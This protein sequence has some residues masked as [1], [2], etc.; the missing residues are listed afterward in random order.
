MRLGAAWLLLVAA[1]HAGP[2]EVG[3]KIRQDTEWSGEVRLMEDVV[4]ARGVTLTIQPGTRIV[5]RE[6]VHGTGPG[7]ND[8]RLELHVA[9]RILA[10]GRRAQPIRF[11][12]AQDEEADLDSPV[13]LG[14]VMLHRRRERSEF[15]WCVFERADTGI[16]VA[17]ARVRMRNCVFLR[18]GAGVG[19]SLWA[20]PESVAYQARE[21][22]PRLERCRFAH[23]EVG[24]SI[25]I[26]ARPELKRCIFVQCDSG[27]ANRR[28]GATY[29]HSGVGPL[30]ERCEFLECREAIE[31]GSRVTNSIFTANGLVFSSSRGHRIYVTEIDR[32]LRSHNL[33]WDNTRLANDDIPLGAGSRVDDPRR[34]GELPDEIELEFLLNDPGQ[35]LALKEG[36]PGRGAA[37]DQ[38]DL[39]AFGRAGANP[40]W[41]VR[42]DATGG[43]ALSHWLVAWSLVGSGKTFVIPKSKPPHPGDIDKSGIWIAVPPSK[44]DPR[45]PGPDLLGP[46]MKQSRLAVACVE[47]EAE[48]SAEL[49]IG[50]D[51]E[52]TAYWNGERIV[53]KVPMRRYAPDDLRRR[54]QLVKG[55]NILALLVKPRFARARLLVRLCTP[56]ET[57]SP[58][59]VV[60]RRWSPP[61]EVEK[62]LKVFRVQKRRERDARQRPTGLW[63]LTVR[64]AAPVHGGDATNTA[65]Y[66][67]VAGDGSRYPLV[68]VDIRYDPK[69]R[70]VTIGGVAPPRPDSFRMHLGS[71]R[72]V[73][74]RARELDYSPT[75]IVFR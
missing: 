44:A 30:V 49:K 56:G 1:A 7:W 45:L 74:G 50:I 21:S 67:L 10:R 64:F 2:L 4:V 24:V 9:G 71:F 37:D 55:T 62:A 31:G 13:W 65:N 41:E 75:Q 60:P 51:G 66:V 29:T 39:G 19:T 63:T 6:D 12:I 8:E 28:T 18:C 34:K 43:L 46:P 59:G 68:D 57:D 53:R 73:Y 36:S 40:P 22:V 58:P 33:Y 38:G 54:V 35:L 5:P 42:G 14:I 26:E 17:G 11:G 27:I 72:D 3:G 20:G 48:Q 52:L 25:E 70:T 69:K 16:Q 15:D 61:E 32:F 23:C 47:S